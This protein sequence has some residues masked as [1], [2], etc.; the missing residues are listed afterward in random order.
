VTKQSQ[1]EL[2]RTR[3]AWAGRKA[4]QRRRL[5]RAGQSAGAQLAAVAALQA[6]SA[7]RDPSGALPGYL[8]ATAGA[9]VSAEL[10]GA[11]ALL[12]QTAAQVGSY[13]AGLVGTAAV[14]WAANF[15]GVVALAVVVIDLVDRTGALN[16]LNPARRD[17]GT[18]GGQ[19]L[20]TY[21]A[22]A[23][24]AATLARYGVGPEAAAALNRQ[25]VGLHG[26]AG[27]AW[28]AA[29]N[30]SL[31]GCSAWQQI[32]SVVT[33]GAIESCYDEAR[34]AAVARVQAPYL[35]DVQGLV[36]GTILEGA[37]GA[38]A[39]AVLRAAEYRPWEGWAPKPPAPPEPPA[40]AP[41]PLPAPRQTPPPA[42]SAGS[43]LP[44]AALVVAVIAAAQ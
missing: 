31:D 3:A 5:E 43:G 7:G 33:F 44:A 34:R 38:T 37:F 41:A 8:T 30:A 28:A 23:H 26:A 10:A 15:V 35:D 36:E 29:Y 40:P 13:I 20:A 17:L 1:A 24:V 42:A 25:L 4:E 22:P 16:V 32:G 11:E 27:A 6:R 14:A 19:G 21:V 39:Q 2:A 9:Y 18:L 12:G